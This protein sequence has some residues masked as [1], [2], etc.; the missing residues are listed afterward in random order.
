MLRSD[1]R[2]LTTHIG[3]L[4]RPL[5]LLAA[6]TAIQAG[7]GDRAAYEDHLRRSVADVVQRQV[8]VGIDV[9]DDGEYSKLGFRSYID[10]RLGG[11]DA[12]AVPW[13]SPWTG[14]REVLAFPEFYDAEVRPKPGASMTLMVCTGPVVYKGQNALDRDLANLRA[15]TTQAKAQEAFV[16]AISPVDVAQ[17]QRNEHY[18]TEEEFLC[19]IADALRVEYRSIIETGFVLQIDAPLLSNYYMRNPAIDVG[20]FRAWLEKQVEVINYALTGLPED[21]V[22]YHTC[23]GINMGPRL[24]DPE[25]KDIIDII[26]KIRAGAYSFEAANPRH[27][28]EWRI[29]EN[30]KLPEGKSII[31]GVITN[32]SV[33]VEHPDLVAHRILRFAKAVGRDN[34]IAGADCGFG[35]LATTTPEVHPTIV[36]AKFQS[37]VEGARIASGKLWG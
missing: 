23:Y 2:I 25:M 34:V 33:L 17:V 10:E 24:H 13:S 1:A 14:S 8:E 12:V 22:R 9:V 20:Q 26:L 35:T 5:E 36:W 27:E 30:I 37:L 6:T 3:S 11:Y 4:S 32:S 15:A 28:H 7:R 21:K 29:W 16:P 18:R 31:P 19:A